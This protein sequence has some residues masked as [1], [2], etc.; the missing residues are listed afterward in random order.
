VEFE[1]RLVRS[2]GSSVSH[3]T[4]EQCAQIV[5]L[6]EDVINQQNIANGLDLHQSTASRVLRRFHET[7]EYSR[8]PGQGRRG[9]QR[10]RFLLLQSLKHRTLTAPALQV[11]TLGRYQFQISANTVRRR[12]AEYDLRPRIPARGSQLTAAH[13]RVRL[14]FAQNHVDWDL[15][16]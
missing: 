14:V 11:M 10:D 12:L 2:F 16:Q 15:D 8:R 3:T 6:A 4:A 13:R 7:G 5:V 9:T 1:R